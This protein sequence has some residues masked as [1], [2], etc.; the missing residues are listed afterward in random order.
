MSY[1]FGGV[2]FDRFNSFIMRSILNEATVPVSDV[3]STTF[4]NITARASVNGIDTFYAHFCEYQSHLK[5]KCSRCSYHVFVL[6]F[7]WSILIPGLQ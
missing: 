5:Y 7:D 6:Q 1:L 2:R 4:M 3:R